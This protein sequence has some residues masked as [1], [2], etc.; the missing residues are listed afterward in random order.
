MKERSA[1]TFYHSIEEMISACFGAGVHLL[2]MECVPGG[3]INQAYRVTLSSGN[4]IFVKTNAIHN[5]HFFLAEANGLEALRSAETAWRNTVCRPTAYSVTLEIGQAAA[6]S[7]SSGRGCRRQKKAVRMMSDQ[8]REVIDRFTGPYAFLSNFHPCRVTF[9]GMTFPSV[10]AA[11]Q[12][13]KCADHRDRAQFL[14][15]TPE[16]AKRRGRQIRMRDDWDARKRTIMHNLLV[17]KFSENPDLIPKLLATGGAVLVEGN[18]WHDN[19]W[20]CCTCS[21]CGGRRGRNN[22]GRLLMELR[23][24]YMASYKEDGRT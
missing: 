19:Y 1:R 18:T 2:K 7:T 3:D 13:V 17:H 8:H 12:A 16:Q 24:D 23:A 15:M 6:T 10:E 5:V 14:A 20:G 11:F 22:L 9:Y 21:R 4:S